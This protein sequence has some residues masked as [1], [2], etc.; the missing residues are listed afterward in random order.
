MTFL[1][2]CDVNIRQLA[3]LYTDILYS[4][5]CQALRRTKKNEEL[6]LGVSNSPH[7]YNSM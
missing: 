5:N 3:T 4:P 1:S 2:V 6:V 7:V